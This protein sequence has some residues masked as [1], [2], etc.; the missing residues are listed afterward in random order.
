[1]FHSGSAV[2]AVREQRRVGVSAPGMIT[3]AGVEQ[4]IPVGAVHPLEVS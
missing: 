2:Q 1:M 3:T 4:E